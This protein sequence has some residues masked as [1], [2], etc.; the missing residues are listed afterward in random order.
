MVEPRGEEADPPGVGADEPS[1]EGLGVTD[2]MAQPEHPAEPGSLVRGPREH[3]HRVA[4]AE[5][6]SARA[7]PEHVPR[8]FHHDGYGAQ[9]PEDAADADGVPD[10]LP[11]PVPGR[12]VESARVAA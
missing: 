11:H 5:Q 8:Q 4:V 6:V 1:Q 2:R 7:C 10:R 12:N 3:G 9:A